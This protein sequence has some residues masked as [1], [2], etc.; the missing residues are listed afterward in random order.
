MFQRVHRIGKSVRGK[1]RLILACFLLY[2]GRETML[3][4]GFKLKDTEYMILQD[5]PQEIIHR[6]RKQMPKL[7]EAKK[8]GHRVSF[9]KSEPDR[10]LIDGKFISA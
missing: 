1:P 3:R 10:L 6:R 9:S 8:M 7:K 2:R 4:A 5:F